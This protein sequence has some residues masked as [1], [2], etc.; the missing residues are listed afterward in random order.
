MEPFEAEFETYLFER[1][2]KPSC[3][4]TLSIFYMLKPVILRSWQIMARRRIAKKSKQTFP[5]WPC[6]PY[7]EIK[8]R[9]MIKARET[10]DELPFIWFWPEGKRLVCALTHDIETEQGLDNV[11][12]ICTIEKKYGL[13]SSWNFVVEKYKIPLS[14]VDHLR[15][16]G[17]EVGIHGLKHDGK[18]FSSRAIFDRRTARMKDY[19]EKMSAVGFR[20]PSLIRNAEWIKVLPFEY[21]SSFPDTDPFGPQP[22]GCLSVFPYFIGPLVELPVTLAQD[23]TLF[24]ILGHRDISVWQQKLD[25]IEKMNGLALMIAHPDYMCTRERF[26]FYEEFLRY[27]LAKNNIWF[28]LPRDVCRWWKERDNSTIIGSGRNRSIAG[29]AQDKGTIAWLQCENGVPA[30]RLGKS[31]IPFF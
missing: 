30:V 27:A 26:R 16:E 11:M 7:L 25:W 23:H 17:F 19:A 31:T 29:P 9:E 15:Q 10:A 28:A 4:R 13:R 5:G 20:S 8:K 24:E 22:G 3:R 6:E 2:Q 18:L 12:K 1:Y 14:L 21:D